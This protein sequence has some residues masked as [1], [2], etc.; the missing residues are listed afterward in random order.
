MQRNDINNSEQIKKAL[1][2]FRKDCKPVD[3]NP[4]KSNVDDLDTL[5]KTY[6]LYH[7]HFY[8]LENKEKTSLLHRQ[9]IGFQFDRFSLLGSQ[10]ISAKQTE[11]N[12]TQENTCRK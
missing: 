12:L 8:D 4:E 7:K 3:S 11:T 10:S 6:E 1:E 5:I 9:V 2:Q